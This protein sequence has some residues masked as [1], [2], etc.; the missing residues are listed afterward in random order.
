MNN[1]KRTC[2]VCCIY[3]AQCLIEFT[4]RITLADAVSTWDGD[5]YGGAYP[6]RLLPSIQTNLAALAY[7][8]IRF[9]FLQRQLWVDK[10][11][12]APETR[13]RVCSRLI[14]D[15]KSRCAKSTFPAWFVVF[16]SYFLYD[17]HFVSSKYP[18]DLFGAPSTAQS[19]SSA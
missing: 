18:S 2:E 13:G 12:I 7:F 10:R 15:F 14:G 19:S 6:L 5:T 1:Q 3:I 9:G 4:H 11:H 16:S 8:A 17:F